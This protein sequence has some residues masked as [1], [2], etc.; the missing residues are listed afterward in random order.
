MAVTP[1]S[2]TQPKTPTD[3]PV[4]ANPKGDMSSQDTFMK[5]LVAELKYQDPMDPLQNRD[6]VAQLATLS[7]VQKL[8]GI[9]DKLGGMQQSSLRDASLQSA[10]LIGKTV[11]AQTNRLTLSGLG[12]PAGAFRL[13]NDAKSVT[14]SVIDSKGNPVQNIDLGALKQGQQ[15]FSWDGKSINGQ[16][17]AAGNYTFQVNAADASGAPIVASTQVSGVVSEVAYTNGT[18]E[19]VIGGAHV[20]VSDVTSV[21]Q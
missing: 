8:S 19:I 4:P 21:A 11:T 9:D 2:S 17:V 18:P 3:T 13:A 15:S 1:P 7:S 14:V 5:L 6:M 10:G 16:R 12:E 20:G